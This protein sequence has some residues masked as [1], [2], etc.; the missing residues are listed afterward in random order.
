MPSNMILEMPPWKVCM[1]KTRMMNVELH[2]IKLFIGG[3]SVAHSATPSFVLINHR[4]RIVFLD[5]PDEKFCKTELT[6]HQ[7]SRTHRN[8]CGF[9]DGLIKLTD[10]FESVKALAKR[11]CKQNGDVRTSSG[12]TKSL[13]G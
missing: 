12:S 7:Q 11:S 9:F 4:I 6:L 3:G 2:R 5:Y 8:V 10:W 13:F 1:C